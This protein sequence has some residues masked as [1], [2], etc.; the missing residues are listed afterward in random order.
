MADVAAS[1]LARLKNKAAEVISSA[2][3]FSARKSSCAVWESQS[4]QKIWFLKAD[5]SSILS[6]ILIAVLRRMLIFYSE[7]YLIH[8]NS[9]KR[10]WRRSSQP[11]PA[12]ILSH[13]KSKT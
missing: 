1:V 10:Y 8:R 12:T 7:R 2:Y 5:C 9:L 11:K 6:R 3:S 13:L 4:M